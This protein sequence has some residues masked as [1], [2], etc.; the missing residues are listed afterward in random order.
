MRRLQE[1]EETEKGILCL[2]G[3]KE[4][5]KKGKCWDTKQKSKKWRKSM[6]V[7]QK[8]NNSYI[9][10]V[11]CVCQQSGAG[12]VCWHI[13]KKTPAKKES[14]QK[15]MWR[16]FCVCQQSGGGCREILSACTFTSAAVQLCSVHCVKVK[17][18]NCAMCTV[19]CEL[20]GANS[21]Q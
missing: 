9:W 3:N 8:K 15:K 13:K 18:V 10:C 6:V 16:R 14:L 5:T 1:N 4:W 11:F 21:P 19:K 7:A 17:C 20:W 12:N 2:L